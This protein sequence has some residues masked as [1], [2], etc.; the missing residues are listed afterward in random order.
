MCVNKM[1]INKIE[2]TAVKKKVEAQM[3]KKQNEAQ[4]S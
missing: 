2:I 3:N 1:S 4:P